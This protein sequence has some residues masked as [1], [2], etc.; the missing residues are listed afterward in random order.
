L[1]GDVKRDP[2]GGILACYRARPMSQLVPGPTSQLRLP[3]D[4][5]GAQTPALPLAPEWQ[6]QPRVWPHALHATCTY[7]GSLPPALAHDLIGRWS[8]PGD[9]VLDPFSGRGSVPLQACL[10][11]RIGM[12]IDRNPLAAL[13]TGAAVD[14]PTARELADRLAHLRIDWSWERRVWTDDAA[15]M[16]DSLPAA[17]FHPTTLAQLL[18]VRQALDR[19]APVDRALL[20]A[21]A[22]ILHGRRPSALTDAMPNAFSMAPAYSARWL[23]ARG[24]APPER[25]VF[26]LLERRV[27]RL[28]R[29]GMPQSRGFGIEGDARD[30]GRLA[31]AALGLAGQPDRIRLVVTSPPYL[32]LVRY[33]AANWLRLWLLGEDPASVD[34]RLDAPRSLDASATLL[35]EVLDGLRPALADDAVVVL[36]LGTLTSHRGRRTRAPLD[37]A[38]AAWEGAAAP[39]GFRLAGIVHDDVDGRRKLTRLWG[40]RAGD[41]SRSDGLLV[42]APTEAGRRRAVAGASTPTDWTRTPGA[43][44]D[45][46]RRRARPADGSATGGS[47][48]LVSHAADVSPGRPRVDG[49]ARP[50]EEPRP[51]SDDL[52]TAVV[53][54]PATGA[55]VRP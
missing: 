17:C 51:R 4:G 23:A 33:G 1:I 45:P 6:D 7:L 34:G 28:R 27:A 53:H 38:T 18:F 22:G 47:A 3:L 8:R 37:L 46:P 15:M 10:E 32:G 13:L 31:T 41:A 36:V 29:E 39:S 2:R 30:A 11:R 35:R 54:P 12:G 21:L 49:P 43:R 25:D 48:M 55:P 16:A 40:R 42:I 14:P 26:G 52:A 20:A 44:A 24:S 9:V 19:A 50:D 5:A